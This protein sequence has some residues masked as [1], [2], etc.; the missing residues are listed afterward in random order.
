MESIKTIIQTWCNGDLIELFYDID[1]KTY[2]LII[3]GK[4]K[5]IKNN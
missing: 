1:N 3:N 2:I 4:K 5:I